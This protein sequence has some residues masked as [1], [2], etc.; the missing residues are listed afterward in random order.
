MGWSPREVDD[1]S[2][3]EISMAAKGW[4]KANGAE[5]KPES[6]SEDEHDR[7]MAKYG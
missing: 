7:L 4:A 6:L 5:S 1:A 2:L 3:W